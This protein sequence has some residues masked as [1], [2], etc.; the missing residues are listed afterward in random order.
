MK[1]R[2]VLIINSIL[3]GLQVLAGGTALADVGVP[4]ETVGLFVV[5]VAAVQVGVNFYV[6]GQVVPVQDAVAYVNQAG[7]AVA[8]PAAG[9]TNGTPVDVVAAS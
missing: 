3:A 6:Q 5:G 7:V 4:T 2:P 1:S 9:V 8:G